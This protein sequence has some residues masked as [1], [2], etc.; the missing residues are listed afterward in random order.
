MLV[1]FERPCNS[2]SIRLVNVVDGYLVDWVTKRYVS[3]P[4]DL[5]D[6]LLNVFDSLIDHDLKVWLF[7]QLSDITCDCRKDEDSNKL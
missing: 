5:E 4:I 3:H 1:S 6:E 7:L 2:E